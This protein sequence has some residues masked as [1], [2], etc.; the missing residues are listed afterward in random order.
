MTWFDF[1]AEKNIPLT[2]QQVWAMHW[3][4][5]RGKRFLIDFGY[6]NAVS[7]ADVDVRNVYKM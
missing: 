3:L 1:C 6:M 7:L 5:M 4:T 2:P